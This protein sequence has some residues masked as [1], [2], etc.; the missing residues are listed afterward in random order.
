MVFHP[1]RDPVDELRRP[2]LKSSPSFYPFASL[3]FES[4]LHPRFVIVN[5]GKALQSGNLFQ[6][7]FH[8]VPRDLVNDILLLYRA[9]TRDV[10]SGDKASSFRQS[11]AL[12]PKS[13]AE[14]G[15]I[16]MHS[17][18]TARRRW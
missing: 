6:D 10:P 14:H 18:R 12:I 7:A 11:S 17:E 15:S 4:H 16:G 5:V 13:D 9:W 3:A 2:V 8:V 1:E